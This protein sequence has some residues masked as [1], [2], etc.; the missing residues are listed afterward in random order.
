ASCMLSPTDDG[1]VGNTAAALPFEG[2][3]IEPGAPV[4]IR[5]WNYST[6]AMANVGAPVS[7]STTPFNI[8]GGPL[9]SWSASRASSSSTRG[10]GPARPAR[11]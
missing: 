7:A 1:R 4:Q 11:S 9:Y 5:A 2:F 3:T 10:S 8:D 6:H